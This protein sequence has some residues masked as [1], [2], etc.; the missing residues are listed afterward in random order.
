MYRI[1]QE[2]KGKDVYFKF[3]RSDNGELAL[4]V[5]CENQVVY[6]SM[7]AGTDEKKNKNHAES[8]RNFFPAFDRFHSLGLPIKFSL[9]DN[10]VNNN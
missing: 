6:N 8:L 1:F 7:K 2:H 3:V 10:R 5:L 4:Q 9:K